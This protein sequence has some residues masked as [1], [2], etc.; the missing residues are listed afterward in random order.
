MLCYLTGP[1]GSQVER[2]WIVPAVCAAVL[3]VILA[4]VFALKK[5]IFLRKRPFQGELLNYL[6]LKSSFHVHTT[7]ETKY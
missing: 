3:F 2:Q 5:R 1:S 6:N 4:V 7:Q